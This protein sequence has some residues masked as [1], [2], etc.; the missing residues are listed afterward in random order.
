MGNTHCFRANAAYSLYGVLKGNSDRGCVGGT[1]INSFFTNMGVETFTSVLNDDSGITSDCQEADDDDGG[2]YSSSGGG[3]GGGTSYANKGDYLADTSYGVA[4]DNDTGKFVGKHFRGQNCDGNDVI[5]TIGDLEDFNA[6]MEDVDC[7]E[8]YSSGSDDGGGLDLLTY[9]H[10]CS[11]REYPTECPDPHGKLIKYTRALECATGTTCLLALPETRFGRDVA[12]F[13]L[14][15][16]GISMLFLAYYNPWASSGKPREMSEIDMVRSQSE[17]SGFSVDTSTSSSTI[18][19]VAAAVAKTPTRVLDVM[20]N[21]AEAEEQEDLNESANTT[22]SSFNRIMDGTPA[23]SEEP[24]YVAPSSPA[25]SARSAQTA[26][27]TP[28]ASVRFAPVQQFAPA[29]QPTDDDTATMSPPSIRSAESPAKLKYAVYTSQTVH[30]AAIPAATPAA[31][32][33]MVI[34]GMSKD[35]QV[36]N[37]MLADNKMQQQS[38]YKRPVMARISKKLLGW[39]KKKPATKKGGAEI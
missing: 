38:N 3:Y 23:R 10:A 28:T 12:S 7:F 18:S 1:Y 21:F 17:S 15:V 16:T 37:S 20:Q 32:G 26:A 11:L 22:G 5:A 25:N 27:A 2:D 24:A 19:R 9:S 13:V 33:Q 36:A 34:T 35:E 8:V 31:G 30:A 14:V 29:Q 6:L 39:R 4:C